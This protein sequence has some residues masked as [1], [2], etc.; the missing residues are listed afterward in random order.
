MTF[1]VVN[2]RLAVSTFAHMTYSQ[3]YFGNFITIKNIFI[4]QVSISTHSILIYK[5]DSLSYLN[6]YH[7][8][9][10]VFQ[11][12]VWGTS[13]HCS[14]SMIQFY[15]SNFELKVELVRVINSMNHISDYLYCHVETRQ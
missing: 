13:S 6:V 12:S 10:G 15:F 9:F 8:C 4:I 5:S 7:F 3:E 1:Y 11:P 2:L 14:F